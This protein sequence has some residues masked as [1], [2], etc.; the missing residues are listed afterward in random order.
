MGLRDYTLFDIISRNARLYAQRTA[1]ILEGRRITHGEYLTRVER[2]AAGLA[3]A[4]TGMGDR[5]AIVSLNCLEYLDLYGAAARLGA[6]ILPVNWRLSGEE[7]V[8]AAS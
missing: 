4:G 7:M 2:L 5:I 8:Q 1:I 6:I 3:A